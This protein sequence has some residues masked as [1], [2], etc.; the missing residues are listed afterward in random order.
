[1]SVE[2]IGGAEVAA[3]QA[4]DDDGDDDEEE[5]EDVVEDEDGEAA[6]AGGAV[7]FGFCNHFVGCSSGDVVD[8]VFGVG[9]LFVGRK[10]GFEMVFMGEDV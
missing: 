2:L 3:V 4:H 6:G 9:D 8:L 7:G 1:M 10:R 5:A